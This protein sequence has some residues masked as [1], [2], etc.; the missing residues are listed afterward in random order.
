MTFSRKYGMIDNSIKTVP[1]TAAE[2]GGMLLKRFWKKTNR[3]LWLGLSLL[4][5]LLIFAVVGH[6]RFRME[7]PKIRELAKNYVAD[8]LNVNA[9]LGDANGGEPLTEAQKQAQNNALEAVLSQYWRQGE[10]DISSGYADAAELRKRLITWQKGDPNRLTDLQLRISNDD[11]TVA[12]D[13]P[14]RA[15]VYMQVNLQTATVMGYEPVSKSVDLFPT[16]SPAAK[17]D[18]YGE[19]TMRGSVSVQLELARRGGKWYIVSMNT[20]LGGNDSFYYGYGGLLE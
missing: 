12:G 2:K 6:V 16:A 1:R 3:G 7:K 11:V 13:G 15:K 4:A 8:L 10:K 20:D 14:N 9:A 5:F 19:W 17:G 18:E